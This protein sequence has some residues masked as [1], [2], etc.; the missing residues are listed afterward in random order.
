MDFFS[1]GLQEEY[2]RQGIIIQVSC[3][4]LPDPN[5]GA[6]TVL[7]SSLLVAHSNFLNAASRSSCMSGGLKVRHEAAGR[8]SALVCHRRHLVARL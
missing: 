4:R 2:R 5:P 6:G 7:I 3:R 8:S 1:R